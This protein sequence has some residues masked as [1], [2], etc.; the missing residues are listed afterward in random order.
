L[1]VDLLGFQL[2]REFE[3]TIRYIDFGVKA[4]SMPFC[5][6][7]YYYKSINKTEGEC[8]INGRVEAERDKD[9]CP[10]RTFRPK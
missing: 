1:K 5:Y 2:A 4:C 8:Q 10:S 6:D 9:R 3:I 7:C